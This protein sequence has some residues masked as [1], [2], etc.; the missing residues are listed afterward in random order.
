[1]YDSIFPW[2]AILTWFRHIIYG[3]DGGRGRWSDFYSDP[4]VQSASLGR[5]RRRVAD[6]GE[7]GAEADVLTLH[8]LLGRVDNHGT[9]D[10]GLI[11]KPLRHNPKRFLRWENKRRWETSVKRYTGKITIRINFN[12]PTRFFPSDLSQKRPAGGGRPTAVQLIIM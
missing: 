10:G 5:K 11:A 4:H 6:D 1:M 3:W 7:G 9:S 12:T 2:V 8:P